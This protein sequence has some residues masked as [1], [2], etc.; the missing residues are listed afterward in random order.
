MRVKHKDRMAFVSKEIF[1]SKTGQ[2]YKFIQTAKSTNNQ[3]LEMETTYEP[4]SK[5][6][7]VHYH[8]NQAEDFIVLSGE[9]TVKINSTRKILKQ[10]DTLHVAAGAVHS[11][12]NTSNSKAVVNWKVR[13]A[14]NSEHLFETITGLANDG[15]TNADGKPRILQAAV[16]LR[17]F[18]GEFRLANPAFA[19]QKILFSILAPVAYL[20]GY[21]ATYK[22]YLE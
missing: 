15:K 19:L 18:S 21:R 3:L 13:P 8:P 10:G 12:W 20:F 5:E 1:N 17:K 2:S 16:T 6:P 9:V 22:E 11:M 7:P 14:M 4:F